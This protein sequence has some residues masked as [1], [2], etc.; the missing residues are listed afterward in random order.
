MDTQLPPVR[1]P[2]PDEAR[3]T[4]A[5]AVRHIALGDRMVGPDGFLTCPYDV[6]N[7]CSELLALLEGRLPNR[8]GDDIAEGERA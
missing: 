6:A 3:A 5:T 4:H 1:L 7:S 8:G 2:T